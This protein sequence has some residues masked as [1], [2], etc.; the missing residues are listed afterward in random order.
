MSSHER[1]RL[2]RLADRLRADQSF[3]R[4]VVADP[5]RALARHALT[6][7]QLAAVTS[8]A[9]T[10]IVATGDDFERVWY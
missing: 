1:L 4:A 9:L 6:A 7:A 8:L 3:A 10:L 2:R 5:A